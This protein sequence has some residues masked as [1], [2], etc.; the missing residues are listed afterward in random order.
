MHASHRVTL[1]RYNPVTVA[2]LIDVDVLKY[3]NIPSLDAIDIHYSP[4]LQCQR[5]LLIAID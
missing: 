5:I 3:T 2:E 4:T 1:K